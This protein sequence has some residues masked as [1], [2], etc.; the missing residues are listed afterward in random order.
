MDYIEKILLQDKKRIYEIQ[1]AKEE[2]EKNE[3][4]ECT[5]KPKINQGYVSIDE[6]TN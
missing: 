4:K 2:I 3:L 6:K 1:K 5:F